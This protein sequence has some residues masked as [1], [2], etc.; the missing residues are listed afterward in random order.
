M[1]NKQTNER[2][3]EPRIQASVVPKH[4]GGRFS[5]GP[6]NKFD[7]FPRLCMTIK[8]V[9]RFA[10]NWASAKVPKGKAGF[11]LWPTEYLSV[12]NRTGRASLSIL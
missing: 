12:C 10:P 8:S 3:N 9:W 4:S 11:Q 5:K 7:A 6:G 2:V 1:S